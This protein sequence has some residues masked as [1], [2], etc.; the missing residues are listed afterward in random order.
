MAIKSFITLGLGTWV[1]GNIGLRIKQIITESVGSTN[2]TAL[3]FI[4]EYIRSIL[5][6]DNGL[7]VRLDKT[8]IYDRKLRRFSQ[9][10]YFVLMLTH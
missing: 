9:M 5:P 8:I 4:L 10:I 1:E 3:N 7:K 2:V 6:Q